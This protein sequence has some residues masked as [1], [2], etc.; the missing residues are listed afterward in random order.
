MTGHYHLPYVDYALAT[1]FAVR[2]AG[3]QD[4]A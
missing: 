1:E 2:A 3:G 4:R